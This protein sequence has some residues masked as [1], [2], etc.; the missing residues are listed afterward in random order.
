MKSLVDSGAHAADPETLRARLSVDGYLFFRGLL[1]RT[2]VEAAGTAVRTALAAGGWADAAGRPVGTPRALN[3][4]EAVSD[5]AY[6]K[7]AGSAEFNR[8]PY[9]SPLRAVVRGLLGAEAFSY[10]VKVLRAI[11]PEGDEPPRGRY[12]HQDYIGTAVN[13]MFTTWVPL[14]PIPTHVGGLAVLPGS[15]LG[16]PPQLRVLREQQ[17][18]REGWA[19]TDYV[20]GDVL[21]FH[22]LTSHAALPNRADRLRIS[23]DSRWQAAGQPAPARLVYGPK[24]PGQ[25]EMFS[26][27]FGRQRWWEPIPP[28][29]PIIGPGTPANAAPW[30]RFFPV[31]PSWASRAEKNLRTDVR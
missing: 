3:A 12:V 31:D 7:A 29:Q 24:Q 28:G 30:S 22:C 23:Q 10:P 2:E 1:P 17:A 25:G 4:R 18:E 8:I 6:R 14:M 5:P 26:R 15:H 21:L 16:A 11:Y 9:L 20:P 27:L 19:T 13:D